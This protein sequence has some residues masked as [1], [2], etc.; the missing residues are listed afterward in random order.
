MNQQ[1]TEYIHSFIDFEDVPLDQ[2]IEDLQELKDYAPKEAK[3]FVNLTVQ[4]EYGHHPINQEFYYQRNLTQ[5]ELDL[6]AARDKAQE[7]KQREAELK[8]YESLR[9]KYE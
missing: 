5:E 7:E 2:L 9:K 4:E 6:R 3:I 1:I 8:L